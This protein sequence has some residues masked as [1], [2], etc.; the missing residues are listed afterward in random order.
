[1]AYDQEADINIIKDN[2]SLSFRFWNEINFQTEY[3]EGDGKAALL[4]STSGH[5]KHSPQIS[6]EW[7]LVS[8]LNA[9]FLGMR[10][11]ETFAEV[12]GLGHELKLMM[13]APPWPPSSPV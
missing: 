1:M 12:L 9:Y 2:G 4:F 10:N 3:I 7:T 8:Y 13:G 11:A 6:P 5:D